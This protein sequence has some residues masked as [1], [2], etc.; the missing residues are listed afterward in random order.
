MLGVCVCVWLLGAVAV[1]G[2]SFQTA[3]GE[4]EGEVASRVLYE[5]SSVPIR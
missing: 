2:F 1:V 3:R 4:N 5:G